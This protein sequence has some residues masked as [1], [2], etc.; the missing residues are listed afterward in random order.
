VLIPHKPDAWVTSAEDDP[1]DAAQNGGTPPDVVCRN[2]VSLPVRTAWLPEDSQNGDIAVA[3]N[4]RIVR[5][6]KLR[7]WL[8]SPALAPGAQGWPYHVT[9]TEPNSD[10]AI[11]GLFHRDE[12]Y[13]VLL[14][15][16]ADQHAATTLIPKYV[17]LFGFD[18]AANPFLLYPPKEL[19]GDAKFPQPGVDGVYPLSVAL[20]QKE[21]VGT[22]LG[23]DTLFLMAT[24]E[25]ITDPEILASDGILQRGARG[26]ENQFDELITGMNNTGTRG[27]RSV[28]TNWLIQQLV[29]PSRP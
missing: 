24:A 6:G 14:V 18:C 9:V 5:L 28:P 25:K 7:L 1:D 3:L 11:R 27:P 8:Q 2:D 23:A 26:V 17:Y 21:R 19:N 29:L 15:T 16:T 13:D 22:P 20:I 12:L 10:K 4:R